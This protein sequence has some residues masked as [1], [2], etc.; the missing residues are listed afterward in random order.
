MYKC[1]EAEVDSETQSAKGCSKDHTVEVMCHTVPGLTCESTETNS[2][3]FKRKVPC[4][5]TN[6][7]SYENALLLSIFLGM[8]GID[9]FYL[10]YP[11]IGLLKFCTLGFFFIFQLV[12]VLLIAT[13][14]VGP[15]DG[16]DYV[17]D[18]YGPR[19]IHIVKDNAT[20]Y[21]PQ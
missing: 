1:D 10:G 2:T 11:A 17:I 5:H 20:Y 8:F 7:H 4:R 14:I 6:G 3:E 21:K 18:Y 15:A 19:L 12:D 16:S 9:R 13:Q